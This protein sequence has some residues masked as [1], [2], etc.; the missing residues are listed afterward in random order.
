MTG[1]HNL[2]QRKT[3]TLHCLQ[4][5]LVFEGLVFGR[6]DVSRWD[7]PIGLVSDRRLESAKLNVSE[8][9]TIIFH[10]MEVYLRS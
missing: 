3:C 9:R 7:V 10:A 6:Q 5:I 8:S 4:L 1:L 2:C